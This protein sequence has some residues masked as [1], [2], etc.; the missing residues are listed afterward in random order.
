MR[1]DLYNNCQIPFFM[2]SDKISGIC[3]S[4]QFFHWS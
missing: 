4:G 1:N 3:L 2:V